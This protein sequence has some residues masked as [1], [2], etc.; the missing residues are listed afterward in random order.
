[1]F[2]YLLI[3]GD[4]DGEH[5]DPMLLGFVG[6]L[7]DAAARFFVPGDGMSVGHHNDVLVLVVVGAA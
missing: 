5:F 1:M 3:G 4:G 6:R 2:Y 7:L